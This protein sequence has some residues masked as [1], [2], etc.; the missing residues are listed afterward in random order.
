MSDA[1]GW[2]L[3]WGTGTQDLLKGIESG[4]PGTE[5]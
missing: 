5:P 2:T 3:N 4:G 1:L